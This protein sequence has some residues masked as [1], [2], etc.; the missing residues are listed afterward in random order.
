MGSLQINIGSALMHGVGT[1]S[2]PTY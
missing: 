2:N 1:E